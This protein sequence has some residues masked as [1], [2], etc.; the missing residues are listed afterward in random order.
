M[1]QVNLIHLSARNRIINYQFNYFNYFNSIISER[2]S[3]AHTTSL[4]FMNSTNSPTLSIYY[5]AGKLFWDK[6]R[7]YKVQRF[8]PKEDTS[9][10]LEVES[11]SK[12]GEL[13]ED[14]MVNTFLDIFRDSREELYGRL[15]KKKEEEEEEEKIVVEIED[16]NKNTGQNSQNMQNAYPNNAYQQG[17][18]YQNQ[19]LQQYSPEQLQYQQQQYQQQQMLYNQQVMQQQQMMQQQQLMQQQQQQMLLSQQ[20]RR[21]YL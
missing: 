12:Y 9:A 20:A 2:Q 14:D 15:A 18:A 8:V 13:A 10:E 4:H 1:L 11:F 19:Q 17:Y 16:E 3:E 6:I 7:A 5:F 21:E